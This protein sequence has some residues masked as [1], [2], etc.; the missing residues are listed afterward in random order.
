MAKKRGKRPPSEIGAVAELRPFIKDS[1]TKQECLVDSGSAVTIEPAPLKARQ[2][3]TDPNIHLVAANGSTIPSYGKRKRVFTFNNKKYSW[4]VIQACVSRTMIGADFLR[5]YGLMVDVRNNRLLDTVA[6]QAVGAECRPVPK[7]EILSAKEMPTTRFTAVLSSYPELQ[8]HDFKS[9]RVKHGVVHHIETKGRPVHAKVRRLNKQKYDGGKAA[10]FELEKLGI[11]R[12]SNSNWSSPLHMQPKPDGSWR[13]CGDYRN[14]NA[15][16]VEDRYPLPNIRDFANR[17]QGCTIF[18][19]VDLFKGYHQI[20]IAPEDIKKTAIITPWGLFEFTRLSMGLTNAAQAFQRV[21]DEATRGLDFCFV[22]LDDILVASKDEEE[23]E[24]HLHLLFKRLSDYGLA[25]NPDK[26]DLGKGEMTFLGYRITPQGTTPVED[27]VKA[28]LEFPPP[29]SVKGLQ[30]FLGMLNYYRPS[31]K[32]IAETLIPL[33]KATTAKPKDFRWTATEEAAFT[34][35]KEALADFTMLVHPDTEAPLALTVDAS[36]LAV[37]GVLE[38]FNKTTSSW[39]PLGFFSKH[40]REPEKKYSPYDRE[41]LAIYLAIRHFR[42]M[43]DGLPFTV[44]TDHKPLTFA[45]EKTTIP[46]SARQQR[47]LLFISEF[48]TDVRHI[49]GKANSVADALSRPTPIEVDA[50]QTTLM[51]LDY[52]ALAAAQAADPDVQAYLTAITNLKPERVELI[53]G[54]EVIC[55]TSTGR[56]RPIVPSTWRRQVFEL[57]HNLAHPSVRKTKKLVASR[58][59]WHGMSKDLTEWATQCLPC[60]QNKVHR[61][62]KPPQ[63]NFPVPMERFSHVNID[64]VGPLP[65]SKGYRYVLTMIDR[66]TRWVEAIPMVDSLAPTVTSA[67][68]GNWVARF[69]VPQHITSDRGVQF[70]GK[71]WSDMA[72]ALGTQ[73]HFTTSYHAAANGMIERFHRPLKAALKCRLQSTDWADQLTWVLL[74]LRTAPKSDIGAST[75]E[76]LYGATLSVPGA[77]V[78]GDEP[79]DR[80]NIL[81]QVRQ[82]TKARDPTPGTSHDKPLVYFPKHLQQA[83]YVFIRVDKVKKPLES[84]YDG[85]YKVLERKQNTFLLD[86]GLDTNGRQVTDWYSTERLKAAHIDIENPPQAVQRRGPGRPRKQ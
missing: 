79:S 1:T 25:I 46:W 50:V 5:H 14:L 82:M 29:D 36:D 56:K 40:L 74:G 4:S 63:G 52:K 66:T 28:I 20:P 7:N 18:S 65:V 15:K 34:K 51:T 19:K 6:L 59:V 27:K 71:L 80:A 57:L 2:G 8:N 86:L 73:T 61:H 48:T 3:P 37:G 54:T 10:W 70:T 60:Q 85:P 76:L 33:Y 43:V 55:D 11:I 32:G 49:A 78:T 67:F 47:Q 83:P 84:P 26:C 17:L 22:Y 53:P 64:I 24:R 9:P 77:F 30:R 41:L 16:T 58:F 42:D 35:A 68:L 13:P 69:G 75:A 81:T 23:H 21:M 12:R 44:Y 31:V 39:E 72:Q 62:T 45:F 38:Q